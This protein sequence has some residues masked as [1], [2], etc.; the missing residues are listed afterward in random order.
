M[1]RLQIVGRWTTVPACEGDET[2]DRIEPLTVGT[3]EVGLAPAQDSQRN[4]LSHRLD[5][6]RGGEKEVDHRRE[7]EEGSDI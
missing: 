4:D 5:Q 3:I 7:V 2:W 1:T 6:H